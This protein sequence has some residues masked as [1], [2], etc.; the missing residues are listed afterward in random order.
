[1][2]G[3]LLEMW[4]EDTLPVVKPAEHM[5]DVLGEEGDRWQHREEEP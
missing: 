2:I 4:G 3:S 5:Q 1:M